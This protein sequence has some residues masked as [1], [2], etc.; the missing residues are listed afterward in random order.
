MAQAV[1]VATESMTRSGSM[2]LMKNMV[3]TTQSQYDHHSFPVLY[4]HKPLTHSP[5]HLLTHSLQFP[6]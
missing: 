2:V 5:N 1:V 6:L 3:R 4:S